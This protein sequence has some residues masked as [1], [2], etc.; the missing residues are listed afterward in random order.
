MPCTRGTASDAVRQRQVNALDGVLGTDHVA[1][2]AGQAGIEGGR[3]GDGRRELRHGG[4]GAFDHAG[5]AVGDAR[6]AVLFGDLGD[7]Q[8]GDGR[9]VTLIR[10][11]G[12]DLEQV[13]HGRLLQGGHGPQ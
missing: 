9:G 13:Q 7:A 12:V 11:G 6:G 8:R 1:V 3:V 10:N 2:L 5:E 4:K